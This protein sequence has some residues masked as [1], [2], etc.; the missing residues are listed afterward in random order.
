[1]D[2]ENLFIIS[3]FPTEKLPRK[4]LLPNSNWIHAKKGHSNIIYPYPNIINPNPNLKRNGKGIYYYNVPPFK[5]DKYDGD[6]KDGNKHGKGIYYDANG[7]KYDGDWKD[8]YMHGEVIYYTNGKRFEQIWDN[9]SLF[10][11]SE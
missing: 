9:G 1:M 5:G 10:Y 2:H 4:K 8:D 7:N 3:T 11:N 6:W